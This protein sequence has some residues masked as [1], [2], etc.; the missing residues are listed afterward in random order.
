NTFRGQCCGD[1]PMEVL[2]PFLSA[3]RRLLRLRFMRA[4]GGIKYDADDYENNADCIEHFSPL[5]R[6][7]ARLE[8]FRAQKANATRTIWFDPS[9]ASPSPSAWRQTRRA[10]W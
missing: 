5:L 7:N 8:H 6:G 9:T 10:P 3:R 1:T 2:L 4:L